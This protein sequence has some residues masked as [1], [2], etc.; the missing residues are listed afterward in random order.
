MV[1]RKC[2]RR[3]SFK[4]TYQP[5]L[6][7]LEDRLAPALF[8][9]LP[10]TA[11]GTV[12]S[13]RNA[14]VQADSNSDAMNTINLSSGTYALTDVS[15][16][17]LVIQDSNAGIASKTL[18]I[19]GQPGTLI[20]GP[21]QGP[22]TNRVFEIVGTS[23][24]NVTVVFKNL[25]IS[26]GVAHDSGVVGGAAALGG[27]IL[28]DGG[29]VTLS[30]ATVSGNQATGASG[31]AG[32]S[33]AV[34][35]AGGA[36]MPG[37]NAGG[38]GI[39]LA[40]GT[41]SLNN[42]AI[43]NN[44]VVGGKGGAGGTGGS[45]TSGS[46]GVSGADGANG[47]AGVKGGTGLAGG[48]GQAGQPGDAGTKGG[49]GVKGGA[50]GA[51]GTGGNAAGGG[52][53]VASGTVVLLNSTIIGNNADAGAGGS[54][55]KGGVG[56][57]GGVG[58]PGGLGGKGGPGGAGGKGAAGAA[59]NGALGGQGATGGAGATGG[60]GGQGGAGGSGGAGG[61]ALGGGVY[62]HSGSVTLH[63]SIISTDTALGGAGGKGGLGGS[64][65][66]GGAGGFGGAGGTG[67]AAGTGGTATQA[68]L[69]GGAGGNGGN[70][71]K[72]GPAGA[73]GNGGSGG[74]G[75]GAGQ[76][77]D[78]MGGG[79]YV[80][81]GTLTLFSSTLASDI[82][83]GGSGG[84][85]A[86]G[87]SGGA[88]GKGGQGG[89]WVTAAGAGGA[90]GKAGPGG[91]GPAG[92]GASGTAG[93]GGSGGLGGKGGNGGAGG[94]GGSGGNGGGG[95][96]GGIF[97]A[98]GAVSLFLG[99]ITGC[100]AIGGNAGAPGSGGS[101]GTTSASSGT[102]GSGTGGSLK[103][104]VGGGNG[105]KGG[106]GA[107]GGGGG[108]GAPGGTASNA[109]H[110]GAGGNGGGGGNAG[111]GGNAGA[112]GSG[113]NGG[114][115][116][117]G[118][119]F[120]VSGLSVLVSG[121]SLDGFAQKGNADSGG[122]AGTPGNAGQIGAGG[123][124][125]SGT[126]TGSPG[127]AG[128]A[129]ATG[130]TSTAGSAGTKGQ[131]IDQTVDGT[132]VSAETATRLV[133]TT[134]QLIG[135][136][137]GAAFN[138]QV[139]AED[140][141]GDVDPT[142]AGTVNVAILSG[143]GSLG[144]TPAA[145]AQKGLAGFTQLNFS[146]PGDYT[147]DFTATG[148]SDAK[149]DLTAAVFVDQLTE[150]EGTTVPATVKI[151]TMLSGH[152]TDANPSP[153][154]A[155]YE[156]AGTGQWEYSTNGKKWQPITAPSDTQALLL[157][158][159]DELRF[160]P[161][162]FWN[163]Q[164]SLLFEAWD[165]S[166]GVAGETANLI[167][168]GGGTPF[169]IDSGLLDVQVT[170]VHHAPTWTATKVTL[171]PVVPGDTTP[172]GVTVSSA[173][174]KKFSDVDGNPVG[175]AVFG[176]TGTTHGTWQFSIDG[177]TTWRP[178]G[179]VSLTAAR[180]L[181][182]TDQIAFVANSGFAGKVTLQAYAWDGTQGTD[183]D[184][185]DVSKGK[186]G[187]NTA[188]S[189]TVL[190]ASCLANT[191]PTLGDSFGPSLGFIAEN[192][193]SPPIKVST[194]LKSPQT[195][196]DPDPKALKGVAIVGIVGAGVWQYSLNG[197]TWIPVGHVSES[198]ALLLPTTAALRFVPKFDT[199]GQPLLTYRAW[200]QTAGVAGKLFPITATGGAS[201]FSD[202]EATSTLT[203]EFRNHAPTWAGSSVSLT[204]VV[205]P[206]TNPPGDSIG[207]IFAH[208][209]R[210]LDGSTPAGIA[211]LSLSGAAH[212]TWQYSIDLG[213]TWINIPVVSTTTPFLLSG[214]DMIRFLPMAGFVGTVSM[215]VRAWDGTQGTDAE[216]F[217][218]KLKTGGSNAFSTTVLKATCS[219]N[220]V[221]T[222]P[223][224]TGTGAAFSPVVPGDT[225][226]AG[227]SVSSV[228]SSFFS[229]VDGDPVGVAVVGL[230]GTTS[231]MWEFST[232]G[233]APWTPIGTV[234]PAMALLLSG[235]DFIRF[236]ANAGFAGTVTL[237]ANAW[238]GFSG[239]AGKTA[240][241]TA[242]GATGGT[243]TFSTTTLTAGCFVNTAPALGSTTG[244]TLTAVKE[245]ITSAPVTVLSLLTTSGETYT[246]P[247]PGA[248]KGAAIVGA[249]GAGTWQY[250]L[251]GKKFFPVGDVSDSLGL[252]LPSTAK[253]EFVPA[254]DQSGPA[255]LTYLAWDQT[256]GTAGTFFDIGDTG[257]ATAFSLT[258]AT[259]TLTV[260]PVNHAPTWTG[261]SASL[262]PVL[263]GATNPPG[264]TVAAAFGGYFNDVD[265]NSV[266]IAVVGLTGT[267]NG[268]WEFFAGGSWQSFAAG[269]TPATALLLSAND[270]IRFV[271]NAGFTGSATMQVRAWDGT[272][273]NDGTTSNLSGSGAT[274]GSTAFSSTLLTATLV[275]NTAPVL[276]S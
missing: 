103:P 197:T 254:L 15:A 190:T 108:N 114:N 104:I 122:A 22:V 54:G 43:T 32:A 168:V 105:G 57:S 210:D 217:S 96:A 194:L 216:N 191:A 47:Q 81:G 205:P 63:S 93:P 162:A 259:A 31:S 243:T 39:F 157:P 192:T 187:G 154:I 270:M 34:G 72:G 172:A 173:F 234:T 75:G 199:S 238:D 132:T 142:F 25:T 206:A 211:I 80:A 62:V 24:A 66:A 48:A 143:P 166:Q 167:A 117:G 89:G 129:G 14:I 158:A 272:Q 263:P 186:T 20:Q 40:A 106:P 159:A 183:G 53:Y 136:G 95:K 131:S 144:G 176:L 9:P 150:V 200:D 236:V 118:D 213:S 240:D 185:A 121:T 58:G 94:L 153:G 51:G 21:G 180:L 149:L 102:S 209:F 203:V 120:V 229:D 126:T 137:A 85:A 109:S 276:H 91:A 45:G 26:N 49:A 271:P 253:L 155:V 152:V 8:A 42:A 78:G 273:G 46:S 160:L 256:S 107:N 87:G 227:D 23:G 245:N 164:A 123:T 100:G 97:L 219:V 86:A 70:G 202:T 113:G 224:W 3:F 90:G 64:G 56:G 111:N 50:G 2:S 16:G 99:S 250:S 255:T 135:V 148:L 237:V 6:E 141:F 274:G 268:M 184:T 110:D 179:T 170:P 130:N 1:W 88:A 7:A 230:T 67:G 198:S 30:H 76:G 145:G 71:G 241:L 119:I 225:N 207:T 37:G 212:G 28:I 201:P 74:Q 18:T 65:G 233:G 138:V 69:L 83:Q 214:P 98:Q 262:T 17:Q 208:D 260:Q 124:G 11:D 19:V 226:P 251:N 244:P 147:L 73:G 193:T 242:A 133:V 252:L 92:K 257:G 275:V 248:V 4:K 60:S 79:F 177:G 146:Q 52:I 218:G 239:T 247:D 134:Q 5:W 33:G 161:A 223:T 231:G 188:F 84:L 196:T 29:Q 101:G 246:D 38:G 222:A 116:D 36:G 204:P 41:L 61:T 35:Q 10:A 12:G 269:L 264:D 181:S 156:T 112:G 68:G 127:A 258:E 171:P 13:L 59:G 249:T 139:A 82:A 163:G 128:A 215:E 265:G 189:A 27:G 232:D 115:G 44:Q 77:G 261:A 175:I 169:S 125:G 182:G 220:A 235:T 140:P 221:N 267:S 165:G 55:G 178:F 174:G 266:G 195:D 228:L 151:G